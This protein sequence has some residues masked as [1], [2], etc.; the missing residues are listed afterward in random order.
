MI[1]SESLVRMKN[2]APILHE[3]L[4]NVRSSSLSLL[5]LYGNSTVSNE[6]WKVLM[7]DEKVWILKKAVMTYLNILSQYSSGVT[8]ENNKTSQSSR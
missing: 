5:I 2:L 3:T 8:E 1:C 6:N 4:L 7:C